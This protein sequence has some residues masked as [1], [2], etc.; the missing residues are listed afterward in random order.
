[1]TIRKQDHDLEPEM[2][3][4]PAA[5]A[6]LPAITNLLTQARLPTIGVEDHLETFVVVAVN[7]EGS[8]A[9]KEERAD[10]DNPAGVG[11]LVA[12][13]DLVGVGGLVGSGSLVG[14][15]GL[16]VHGRFALLRSLAV[17][18]DHRRQGIASKICG[19]LEEDAVRRGI[20]RVYL[21]T[22]TA[23]SFFAS[24]GYTVATREDAPAKITAT[25]EFTSLCPDSAVLMVWTC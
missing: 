8:A 1:M 10:G 16:E 14:V 15:G 13:D 24:R 7:P 19:R 3:L 25:E 5:S 6:D 12:E 21:L 18:A 2:N 11:G 20:S 17:G 23:E 22:E 9:A 4:R